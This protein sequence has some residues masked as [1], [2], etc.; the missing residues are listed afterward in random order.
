MLLGQALTKD[1]SLPLRFVPEAVKDLT[2]AAGVIEG[3]AA[4]L[5]RSTKQLAESGGPER[6]QVLAYDLAHASAALE[7]ARS[8]LDYGAKGEI[9]AT[10]TCAFVADMVHD[11]S[12]RLL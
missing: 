11:F 12:T 8:L 6:Q 5:R 1:T 7:T 4:L 3:V 10:I 2:V 9:E